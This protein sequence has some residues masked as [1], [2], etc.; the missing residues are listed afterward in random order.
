MPR[1]R[2]IVTVDEQLVWLIAPPESSAGTS[3]PAS[4]MSLELLGARFDA[5]GS[6]A[7]DEVT[8]GVAGAVT[9]ALMEWLRELPELTFVGEPFGGVEGTD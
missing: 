4:A 9:V 5:M 7:A 2:A 1:P 6:V 3:C 8:A